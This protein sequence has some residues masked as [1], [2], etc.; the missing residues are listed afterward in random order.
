MPCHITGGE[1]L[2]SSLHFNFRGQDKI[3]LL[4]TSAPLPCSWSSQGPPE[5]CRETTRHS[6]FVTF[7]I[8]L[9]FLYQSERQVVT[10]PAVRHGPISLNIFLLC[11][12]CFSV[13]SLVLGSTYT[14]PRVP[15]YRCWLVVSCSH[16]FSC[17]FLFSLLH[18]VSPFGWRK[19][20]A[21]A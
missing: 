16:R 5:A 7:S 2:L 14:K 18:F 12:Y 13:V 17:S 15:C 3:F 6:I 1:F 20:A 9:P 4:A 8:F 11:D 19:A 10:N 21:D